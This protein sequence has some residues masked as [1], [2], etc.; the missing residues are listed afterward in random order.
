MDSTLRALLRSE[1]NVHILYSYTN[2][3][4][5]IQQAV[6]YIRLGIEQNEHILF[7]D[8]ER[9]YPQIYKELQKVLTSS[10]L[11]LL[12]F[13]KNFDFYYSSGGYHPPSIV[14]YFNTTVQPFLENDVSFRCWAHVE[15]ATMHEPLDLIRELEEHIDWAVDALSFPLIC[16]YQLDRM[17]VH[18]AQILEETHPYL[19]TDE[20]F[21]DSNGYNKSHPFST[22][23]T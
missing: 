14:E 15:W 4:L 22:S 10:D 13:I 3:D 23:I 1:R 9:L 19:L 21:K 18:L 6:N 2:M 8:N 16:A 12:H 11:E 7:I 20:S 17:P 5:Y